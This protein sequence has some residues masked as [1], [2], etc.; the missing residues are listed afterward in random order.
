M[1]DRVEIPCVAVPGLVG[2]IQSI[3]TWIAEG[4]PEPA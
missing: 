1:I 4:R 3:P 2:A